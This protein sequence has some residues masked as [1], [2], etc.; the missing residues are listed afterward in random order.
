MLKCD[1]TSWED[2]AKLFE[3]TIGKS[4]A[5]RIDIVVANAGI[6]GQDPVFLDDCKLEFPDPF[7]VLPVTA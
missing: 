2:Q 3:K 1:V 5:G 7:L 4:P 6:S